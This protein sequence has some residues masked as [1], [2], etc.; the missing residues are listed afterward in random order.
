[1]A[2]IKL[3]NVDINFP[4]FNANARSLKQ[5]I[6]TIA[7]GGGIVADEN[8]LVVVSA[9]S[10]LNI[11]LND[12]DKVGLIGHNGSGKSTLL[13]VLGGIYAPV[14]GQ[15]YIEGRIGSLIDMWL[16]IDYE[17][18]GRE[19]IYMRGALNGLTKAEIK[20]EI[21]DIAKFA[22][23]G[24]FLDMPVRTY[25]SGMYLR[26]AFSIAT[27]L[28]SDILLMDEW[29]S[30]GDGEFQI[31]AQQRIIDLISSTKIMVLASHSKELIKNTCNKVIWLEHGKIKRSGKPSQ[32][33]D[34]Y[35]NDT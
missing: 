15:I 13:R 32:I 7:T 21:L 34:E 28:K 18:T 35:F 16:G 22:E 11:T 4:I 1:M 23:L 10:G 30:V 12:G 6:L 19:N 17:S 20:E 31:R 25:S 8:G 24:H 27:I 2:L 14:N 5:K 26:L 3:E 33:L 29:L 9:L